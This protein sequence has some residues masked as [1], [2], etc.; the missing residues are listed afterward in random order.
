MARVYASIQVPAPAETVFDYVSTPLNAPLWHPTS[1]GVSGA[2]DHPVEAGERFTEEL[3]VAAGRRVHAIWTVVERAFPQR[4][5]IEGTFAGIGRG[6][7]TWTFR[8][9]EDG[10]LCTREFVYAMTNPFWAAMDWLF[11]RRRIEVE[12]RQAVR[13]LRDVF[14]QAR[15]R[16]PGGTH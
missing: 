4:W 8:A 7:I 5:A 13:N 10:T 1:L 11:L 15:E 16:P 2:T 9:Q 14:L 6:N 3:L 12:G